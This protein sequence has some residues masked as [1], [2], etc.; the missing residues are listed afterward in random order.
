MTTPTTSTQVVIHA[1]DAAEVSYEFW[2]DIVGVMRT[3]TP[4]SAVLSEED[5]SAIIAEFGP[6]CTRAGVAANALN[7]VDMVSVAPRQ[8]TPV[9]RTRMC[10]AEK[11]HILT[12]ARHTN[13]E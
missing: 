11:Q 12:N 10:C 5:V 7:A 9:I 6:A 4:A 13:M 8:A 1:V 2:D 3:G